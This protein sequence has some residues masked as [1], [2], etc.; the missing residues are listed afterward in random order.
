MEQVIAVTNRLL[1]RRFSAAD[2]AGFLRFGAD[3]EIML[4]AGAAP[5]FDGASAQRELAFMINDALC[6]AVVLRETGEVIGKIRL[7]SDAR[8]YKVNALSVGYE[9]ARMYHGH[10]Y[11]AEALTAVVRYAFSQLRLE[12]LAASHFVG[13]RPSQRVIE[14]AGFYFEGV[15]PRSFCRFD[16]A[17]FDEAVY[18]L[19]RGEFET[20][21]P[22]AVRGYR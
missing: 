8:R 21:R 4:Q 10:G 3:P 9:L 13:N 17:I 15:E 14:R 11:M 7:Q 16:G 18:S 1:L 20:G 19:L 2:M 22:D 5:I 6:F 12:V